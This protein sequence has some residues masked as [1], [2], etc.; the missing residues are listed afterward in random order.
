METI[1]EQPAGV[2]FLESENQ[3]MIANMIRDFG[4]REIRPK[5]MQWDE[6]QHFPIELF[7]KLGGL[8]LMGVLVPE[9]YGGSGFGYHEYV[10]AIAELSKIDG[11]IGLSMA[12]HNSLCTGHILQF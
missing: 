3:K 12:A 10:T 5:M 4:D 8:G 2:S 1:L 7:R 9:E 6:D 11:S